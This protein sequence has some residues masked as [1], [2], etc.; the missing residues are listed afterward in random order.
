MPAERRHAGCGLVV[1]PQQ[2]PEV[3]V[4]GGVSGCP[5]C[6]YHDDVFIYTIDTDSW[7]GG[8]K[9]ICVQGDHSGCAKPPVDV[10][11]KHPFLYMGLILKWNF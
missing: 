1:N 11:T 10:K 6:S 9:L 7:R 5:D 2:G 4:A 3:I 8:K